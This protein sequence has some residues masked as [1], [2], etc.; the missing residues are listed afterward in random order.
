MFTV[1]DCSQLI[2]PVS[3]ALKNWLRLTEKESQE[4]HCSALFIGMWLF[5]KDSMLC[6]RLADNSELTVTDKSDN[7]RVIET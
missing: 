1:I 4:S 6:L 5:F 7:K 2:H 3:E